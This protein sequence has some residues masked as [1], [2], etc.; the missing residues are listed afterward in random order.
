MSNFIF[1][2]A[3]VISLLLDPAIDQILCGFDNEQA[4]GFMYLEDDCF[5]IYLFNF[6]EYKLLTAFL[7]SNFHAYFGGYFSKR[8]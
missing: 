3:L 5:P 4:H 1:S 7:T 2:I 6:P 8:S